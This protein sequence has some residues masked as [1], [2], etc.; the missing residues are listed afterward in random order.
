MPDLVLTRFAYGLEAG[1]S[2]ARGVVHQ[3]PQ[4]VRVFVVEMV[5]GSSAT[6]GEPAPAFD[7]SFVRMLAKRASRL[8]ASP[9]LRVSL[10]IMA[11]L[12]LWHEA[13]HKGKG[14]A[15]KEYREAIEDFTWLLTEINSQLAVGTLVAKDASASI[16]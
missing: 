7:P 8:S 5:H 1:A 16:V 2:T 14:K 4:E 11:S 3:E 13:F 10:Q 15:S 6:L 9:V 12:Y